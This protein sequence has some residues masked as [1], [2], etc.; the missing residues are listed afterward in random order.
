MTE[1]D[2]WLTD[3]GQALLALAEMYGVL[4][5][6]L[7]GNGVRRNTSQ[8]AILGVLRAL[9]APLAGP[10]DALDALLQVQAEREARLLPPTTVAWEGDQ[11]VVPLRLAERVA[12]R[13]VE[14]RLELEDGE[15][16]TWRWKARGTSRKQVRA[17]ELRFPGAEPP[18]PDHLLFLANPVPNGIHAFHVRASGREARTWIVRAP[19]TTW[20]P[21]RKE[22][23]ARDL[24]LFLPLHAL[25]TRR[26]WG[27]G[28]LTDLRA[29]LEWTRER[30]I[31]FVGMLPLLAAFLKPKSGPFEPGPY[32]PASRLFWNELYLDVERVVAS[33]GSTASALTVLA[34]RALRDEVSRLREAP[35]VRYAEAMAVKRHVLEGLVDEVAPLDRPLDGSL[36]EYAARRPDA[37]DYAR[38]RAVG[39]RLATSWRNWPS[40]L[41]EGRLGLAAHDIRQ[42]PLDF[43]DER[44]FR[45]HLYVQH[46]FEAQLAELATET[47][48]PLPTLYLDLPLGAHPDGYDVWRYRDAF[49]LEL[50]G[51]APPDAFFAGGQ[52]WGFPPLHPER[53]REDGHAYT[54]RSLAHLM[55]AAGMIRV[56]HVMSLQRLYCIP[57]GHDAKSGA[58]VRHPSEELYAVLCLESHRWKCEVVGEDLGTVPHE[59]R[60][61]MERHRLRRM[62]VLPFELEMADQHAEPKG[63]ETRAGVSAEAVHRRAPAHRFRTP[64]PLSVAS[65]GT[66]DLPT[67]AA[68]WSG[69]DIERREQLGFLR[70]HEADQERRDRAGWWM[71]MAEALFEQDAAQP[72]SFLEVSEALRSAL[73]FLAA[74]PA[75]HLLVSVEDLWQETEPQNMPGTASDRNWTVKALHSLEN[76]AYVPDLERTLAALVVTR[77]G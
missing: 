30:G 23:R 24:G 46:A 68:Y 45:Y 58:Y 7:D 25:R 76:W 33:E 6:Y 74:S 47:G 4:P 55:R 73:H 17:H 64:H 15:S 37:L 60:E 70:K 5:S 57:A 71:A 67:F 75:R 14:C 19:R 31:A 49:A 54:R 48:R 38:F 56:D 3:D 66:H 53:T 20:D 39:E 12:A 40:P 1:R 8:E 42:L 44:V 61:A 50:S 63:A 26:S 32:A 72:S 9:G 34:S 35:R 18:T 43:R 59:V 10:D 51:G 29:L 16:R 62:Y 13:G 11:V 28:D 41:R 65:L 22:G 21:W 2:T 27:T 77:H 52:D 69:D 36:A